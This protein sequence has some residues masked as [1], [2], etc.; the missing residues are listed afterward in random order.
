VSNFEK[1][2][3]TNLT[4]LL[5]CGTKMI[6]TGSCPDQYPVHQNTAILSLQWCAGVALPE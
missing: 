5:V 6:G 3:T 1:V 4:C 2:K